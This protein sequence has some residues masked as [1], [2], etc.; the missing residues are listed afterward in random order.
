M[1]LTEV[2]PFRPALPGLE[3]GVGARGSREFPGPV[4]FVCTLF[5]LVV[6]GAASWIL[7]SKRY[8]PLT[9]EIVEMNDP[10]DAVTPIHHRQHR[11]QTLF[12]DF[13]G[14]TH[15]LVRVQA[16]RAPGH[17]LVHE[18]TSQV[19]MASNGT[20]QV[21][22]R[23]DPFQ[24]PLRTQDKG[25]AKPLGIHFRERSFDACTQRYRGNLLTGKH[26]FAESNGKPFAQMPSRVRPLEIL[27]L[28]VAFP[29]ESHR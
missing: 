17:Q 11:N 5:L 25:R 21:T 15:G 8:L 6:P 22:I 19:S 13:Q 28:E 29:D 27:R 16:G 26:Q 2:V 18:F 9:Q 24:F 4:E 7:R 23:E 14:I 1:E 20:T 10:R 12:H 3:R